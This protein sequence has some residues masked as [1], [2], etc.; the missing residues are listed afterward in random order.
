MSSAIMDVSERSG[1]TSMRPSEAQLGVF[2]N[3]RSG[4][5]PSNLPRP[6][7]LNDRTEAA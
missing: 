1:D 2:N 6:H 3:S 4:T 5:Y 7:C